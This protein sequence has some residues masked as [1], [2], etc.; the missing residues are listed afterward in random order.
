MEHKAP[1]E[2]L[3]RHIDRIKPDTVLVAD[4]DLASAV[5]VGFK[6]FKPYD[7]TW[8]PALLFVSVATFSL[9]LLAACRKTEYKK[10]IALYSVFSVL[11][12]FSTHFI[13]QI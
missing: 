9:F 10:K 7:Q 6:G 1:G 5:G 4:E 12:L 3:L 8:K 2:F 11:I 13:M